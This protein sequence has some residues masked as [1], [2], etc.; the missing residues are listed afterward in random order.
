VSNGLDGAGG[1]RGGGVEQYT[2]VGAII[3]Y[4]LTEGAVGT[5]GCHFESL[6]CVLKAE[7]ALML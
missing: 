4:L 2:Q 5:G 1:G 6:D 3:A 7:A